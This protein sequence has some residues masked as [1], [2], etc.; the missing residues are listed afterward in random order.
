MKIP[1]NKN[2]RWVSNVHAS[3]SQ[4]EDTQKVSIMKEAGTDCVNDLLVLCESYLERPIE[5][6]EDLVNGWNALR[7]ARQLKGGWTLENGLAHGIFHECGCP[8]VRSGLIDLHPVQCLCSLGMMEIIFSKVTS[9]TV[10]VE[11][12]RTIGNGDDVCEFIVTL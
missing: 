1:I 7:N 8:L 5:T 11:S 10:T 6:V 4:L 12:R 9:K 3:I 2:R